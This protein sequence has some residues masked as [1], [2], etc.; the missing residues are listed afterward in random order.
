M[1]ITRG[2]SPN[3]PRLAPPKKYEKAVF[4]SDSI[5]CEPNRPIRSAEIS[6]GK[7]AEAV[8]YRE[9]AALPQDLLLKIHLLQRLE[10]LSRQI[11]VSDTANVIGRQ[12]EMAP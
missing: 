6:F 10:A 5:P 8:T 9:L 7:I 1:F 2:A 11:V 3:V 4:P 12:I